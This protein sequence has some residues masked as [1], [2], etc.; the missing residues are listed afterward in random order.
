MKIIWWVKSP[1]VSSALI[2]SGITWVFTGSGIWNYEK[3]C[4]TIVLYFE[5]K[6]ST[7]FLYAPDLTL[8]SVDYVNNMS[9][10]D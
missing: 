3:L 6:L 5:V 9:G 10:F 1:F 4:I 7:N 8:T 2:K